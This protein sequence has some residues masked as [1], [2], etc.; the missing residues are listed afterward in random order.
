MDYEPIKETFATLNNDITT[1]MQSIH[2]QLADLSR[3]VLNTHS[4]T[5]PVRTDAAE[6]DRQCNVIV[7]GIPESSDRN[8]WRGRVLEVLR[9]AMLL[10]MRFRFLTPFD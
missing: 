8:E 10:V 3:M 2:K 7:F 9:R 6:R 4:G 1:S 5:K